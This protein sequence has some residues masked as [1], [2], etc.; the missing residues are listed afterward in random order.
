M[1]KLPVPTEAQE[2]EMLVAYLRTR[3][4]T[5]SHIANE[6]GHTLE[7]K[8]RAVRM[9]R[10]GT[11]RGFP[12][13]VIVLPG[14]GVIYIEL[15]RR[16]GSAISPEQKNWIAAINTCPGAEARICKG[17]DECKAFIEELYP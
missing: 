16:K 15:K 17:F 1:N 9:K 4:I 2:G 6:T 14:V 12:D 8:R 10:Q 7:A 13:Y 5:F 3:G 11:S